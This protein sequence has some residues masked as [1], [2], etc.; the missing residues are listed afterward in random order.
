VSR[1]SG[2]EGSNRERDIRKKF[3]EQDLIEAVILLPENLFYNTTAPGVIIVLNKNKKHKEEILLINA[4][5]KYEKGRP[6]NILTG[7]DEIAEVYHNWKEVEKF[8]KIITKEEAQKNDYNL[9][10]SRYITIAEEEEIIPLDDAV[11]LV[12]EAEEE[13]IRAEKELKEILEEA[14]GIEM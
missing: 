5:E 1:G 10:P 9:S 2:A 14:L 4:S 3:V 7:I 13:R 12:K 6:K 11:V 8:S